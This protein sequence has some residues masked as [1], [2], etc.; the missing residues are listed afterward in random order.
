MPNKP[1]LYEMLSKAEE[2]WIHIPDEES[3]KDWKHENAVAYNQMN[4]QM[5]KQKFYVKIFD[6]LKENRIDG[7]YHEFGVHRAR[8]FR[9]A[10]T[11]ARRSNMDNMQFYAYDSFEGLPQTNSNPS[12]EQW[13]NKGALATSEENFLTLVN[14][15][16]IYKDKIHTVKGFYSDSLT[17]ELQNKIGATNRKLALACIDCDLYESA[18]DVFKYIDPL[19]QDG[20]SIYI[21]DLFTGYRGLPTKGVA[22]AFLEYQ[23]YSKFHFVPHMQIGWWGRSYIACKEKPPEGVL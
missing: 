4:R 17:M 5:E 9:M 23:K 16:G 11:E 2:P 22:R 1:S 8:T 13:S 7:D 21:D 19:L 12:Q 15:H 18:V 10:L 20:S 14:Q 6:F 3:L